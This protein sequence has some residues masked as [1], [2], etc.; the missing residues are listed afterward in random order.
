M[1]LEYT[2]AESQNAK[3]LAQVAAFNSISL[4]SVQGDSGAVISQLKTDLAQHKELLDSRE[5]ELAQLRS[6]VAAMEATLG[7]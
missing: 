2:A 7:K 1:R 3:R 6:S 4:D 5:A